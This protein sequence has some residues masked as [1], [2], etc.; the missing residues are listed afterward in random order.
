MPNDER[1]TLEEQS[2]DVSTKILVPVSEDF[3]LDFAGV[4]D[5]RVLE[6]AR[7]GDEDAFRALVEPHRRELHAVPASIEALALEGERGGEV[8]GFAPPS[9][10]PN[11]GLP[12][13]SA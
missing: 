9:L 5:P 3:L 13:E 12:A 11:A 10:S 1:R 7:R 8:I 2:H 6:A 4:R